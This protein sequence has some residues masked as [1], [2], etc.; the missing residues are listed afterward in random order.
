MPQS[1]LDSLLSM[2]VTGG[3]VVWL[4]IAFSLLALTVI[5]LKLGQLIALRQRPGNVVDKAMALL[6]ADQPLEAQMLVNG[7]SNPRAILLSHALKMQASGEYSATEIREEALRRARLG[8]ARQESHLRILEVIAMLAPLLGLFGTVLGMIEAFRAMES[9]GA[10]V[11]PAIL[12]GG[13]W[14][15]LL[16]TAVGLAV[17]IPVSIAHSWFER[18]LE[19][20]AGSL[21]NDVDVLSSLVAHKQ[22]PESVVVSRKPL[23]RAVS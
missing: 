16:T 2:L 4:L 5:L 20:Q 23:Q 19:V 15:A 14:Q 1:T 13:I 10:Q 22:K 17:A 8:L 11:N 7:Q 6:Q 18:K 21:Q 12:S 9:A 3:P